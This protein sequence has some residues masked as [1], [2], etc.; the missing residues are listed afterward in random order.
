MRAEGLFIHHVG[1]MLS[2]TPCLLLSSLIP[3]GP[4]VPPFPPFPPFPPPPHPPPSFRLLI[5]FR[6]PLNTL[7]AP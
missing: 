4:F 3:S 6:N 5:S 2:P 1:G 7:L